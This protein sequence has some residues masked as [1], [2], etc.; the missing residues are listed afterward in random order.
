[1][2]FDLKAFDRRPSAVAA[3]LVAFSA[4]AGSAVALFAIVPLI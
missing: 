2:Q 3:I 1:M 4:A